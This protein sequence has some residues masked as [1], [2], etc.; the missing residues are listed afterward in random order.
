MAK[1]TRDQFS[2]FLCANNDYGTCCAVGVLNVPVSFAD[3]V[4]P[5]GVYEEAAARE[6]SNLFV[7]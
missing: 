1:R 7:W 3:A 5:N 2:V 4:A 6:Y